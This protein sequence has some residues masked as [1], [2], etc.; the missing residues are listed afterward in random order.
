MPADELAARWRRGASRRRVVESRARR[1]GRARPRARRPSGPVVVAGSLY[2]VG[3]ARGRL[4][5]DPVLR[6]PEPVEDA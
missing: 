3:V 5:D 2:L 6:D 4:V 1:R